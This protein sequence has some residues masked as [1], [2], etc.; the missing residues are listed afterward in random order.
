MDERN[1]VTVS[2]ADVSD[3]IASRCDA[4][5]L[6][7]GEQFVDVLLEDVDFGGLPEY[8]EEIVVGQEVEARKRVSFQLHRDKWRVISDLYTDLDILHTVIND[9]KAL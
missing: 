2:A 5:R 7:A 8:F 4:E 3:A 9:C 6:D 1:D